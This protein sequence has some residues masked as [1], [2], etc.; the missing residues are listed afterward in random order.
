MIGLGEDSTRPGGPGL[1]ILVAGAHPDDP[2]TG[3]GGTI[4]RCTSAGHQVVCLYLTRGE[5]G[6]AG[7]TAREASEIRTA[8]ALAA[9]EIMKARPLFAGQMDG[10]TVVDREQYGRMSEILESERPDLVLAHW[11]I[12][13]HPD[14]RVTSHLIYHAWNS[15][16]FSA[17]QAFELYYY[18]VLSGAQTQNFHPTDYVD[19]SD[20]EA[21]KKRACYA[22]ESQNMTETYAHH[23]MMSIFRGLENNC[24]HA[25]AFVR[26]G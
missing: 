18:E 12:D 23:E 7:T 13:T 19:I 17:E 26:Q 11:P 9:C 14:H 25:E 3:C 22:H 5:A 8:E 21:V 1:K 16:R 4:V 2:E 24:R 20:T 6:I 15:T 10:D